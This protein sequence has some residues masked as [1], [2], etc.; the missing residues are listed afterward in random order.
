MVHP[1]QDFSSKL[2]WLANSEKKLHRLENGQRTYVNQV[3][4]YPEDV[5]HPNK[6]EWND[7]G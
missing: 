6:G 1:H 5:V 2:W 3:V 7:A 4:K